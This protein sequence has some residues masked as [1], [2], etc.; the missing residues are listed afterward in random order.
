MGDTIEDRIEENRIE[1]DR[2][3]EDRIEAQDI[4]DAVTG[5]LL[6]LV[7]VLPPDQVGLGFILDDIAG[8]IREAEK[9]IR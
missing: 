5:K 2:I 1:E 9:L 3:E 6:F 4:L 7:S 8:Q